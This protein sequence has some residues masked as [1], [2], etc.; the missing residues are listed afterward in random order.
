MSAH[1]NNKAIEFNMD[2]VFEFRMLKKIM[3]GHSLT[4]EDLDEIREEKYVPEPK[5]DER[6][7]DDAG[8][9]IRGEL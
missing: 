6:D 8:Q 5:W 3:E 1:I 7:A 4:K 2:D 9:P